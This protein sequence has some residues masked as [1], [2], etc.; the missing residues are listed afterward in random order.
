MKWDG[1]KKYWRNFTYQVLVV[2]V[3]KEPPAMLIK[4]P[5][6]GGDLLQLGTPNLLTSSAHHLCWNAELHG[7]LQAWII[8]NIYTNKTLK[9]RCHFTL[10]PLTESLLLNPTPNI[11]LFDCFL[12]LTDDILLFLDQDCCCSLLYFFLAWPGE[13]RRSTTCI[14]VECLRSHGFG[15]ILMN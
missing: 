6:P 10:S 1:Q 5:V 8:C 4:V 9:L 13:K 7:E 11:E 14:R 12:L 2:A 3:A 15:Y